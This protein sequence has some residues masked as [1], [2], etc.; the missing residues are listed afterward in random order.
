MTGFLYRLILLAAFCLAMHSGTAAAGGPP[1]NINGQSVGHVT[2]GGSHGP[3]S[4]T[5]SNISGKLTNNGTV[6]GGTQPGTPKTLSLS[7]FSSE[8]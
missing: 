3:V 2:I 4:V 6:M 1:V 5:N 8:T 7:D